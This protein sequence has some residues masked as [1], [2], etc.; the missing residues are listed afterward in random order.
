MACSG[1]GVGDRLALNKETGWV[2]RERL[3]LDVVEGRPG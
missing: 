2:R 1:Y 3:A